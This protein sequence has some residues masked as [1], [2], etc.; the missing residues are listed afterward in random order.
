MRKVMVIVLVMAAVSI[1]F[2]QDGWGGSPKKENRNAICSK[3]NI[4]KARDQFTALHKAKKYTEAIGILQ[5]YFDSCVQ[6]E[7]LG[8]L[9]YWLASDLSLAY[10]RSGQ[11]EQCLKVLERAISQDEDSPASLDDIV[12]VTGNKKL[13]HAMRTNVFL[14]AKEGCNIH[15]TS[16]CLDAKLYM[17]EQA[18]DDGSYAEKNCKIKGF[19]HGIEVQSAT[20]SGKSC[21]VI[22]K[23]QEEVSWDYDN[24]DKIIEMPVDEVCPHLV[25]VSQSTNGKIV[26]EAV[27]LP[28]ESYLT[29]HSS[30]CEVPSL[31]VSTDT[32]GKIR[33]FSG[34]VRD[35][36]GGTRMVS[37]ENVFYWDGSKI[38][39]MEDHSMAIH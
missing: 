31:S 17:A 4:A 6:N 16:L 34:L 15:A 7:R 23:P 5:P 3:G 2:A 10:L 25:C 26:K 39:K 32:P 9:R 11:S 8:D 28:E 38:Y 24:L 30:C 36:F 29:D 21:L 20:D 18:L 27:A 35:C 22:E 37:L 14:C 1:Q 12:S 13:V 33:V 19:E